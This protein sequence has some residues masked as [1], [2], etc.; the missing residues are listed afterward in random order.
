MHNLETPHPGNPGWG[1]AHKRGIATI[2][3]SGSANGEQYQFEI[4][5]T[6]IE[7][8]YVKNFYDS[9]YAGNTEKINKI[10]TAVSFLN[11]VYYNE[12]QLKYVMDGAPVQYEYAG[13]DVCPHG[14]D[15]CNSS[16]G[17]SCSSHHKNIGRI[18]AEM[19]YNFFESNHIVVMWSDS[20]TDTFCVT[21]EHTHKTISALA[22]TMFV[23]GDP[24]P[25]IQVFQNDASHETES[26]AINLAHEVAHTLGLKE[27]YENEYHDDSLVNGTTWHADTENKNNACIMKY[28]DGYLP[29]TLYTNVTLWSEPALCDYCVGKLKF[30]MLDDVY[31]G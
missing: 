21:E 4:N 28:Y 19:Y 7:T 2:T 31:E 13:V 17:T 16:C 22:A 5:V 30:Y 24:I 27:I 23:G 14:E 25:V 18:A 15:E 8:V 6:S 10:S 26:M 11:S 3:A 9:T 20:G 12:F 29:S 1:I